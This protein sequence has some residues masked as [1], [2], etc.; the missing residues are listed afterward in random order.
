MTKVVW[1]GKSL[2]QG[3][4]KLTKLSQWE[5]V[6]KKA[7]L[8]IL[9]A[10]FR[11]PKV[12]KTPRRK[13]N[14]GSRGV[15]K[16]TMTGLVW[17]TGHPGVRQKSR[18]E[19]YYPHKVWKRVKQQAEAS[20]SLTSSVQAQGLQVPP[21]CLPWWKPRP[22]SIRVRPELTLH[23]VQN[24]RSLAPKPRAHTPFN[25]APL[26]LGRGPREGPAPIRKATHL[27][28]L[29]VAVFIAKK[30]ETTRMPIPKGVIKQSEPIHKNLV[31]QNTGEPGSTEGRGRVHDNPRG[32]NKLQKSRQGDSTVWTE[33]C[34]HTRYA[35]GCT[36]KDS[37]RIHAKA[38]ACI[39]THACGA[40]EKD[41]LFLFFTLYTPGL[42]TTF[43]I[44]CLCDLKL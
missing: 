13:T 4:T 16:K 7:N 34:I 9:S 3:I 28:L 43:L 39:Y 44:Y 27:S 31:V 20:C 19:N 8:V 37:R 33:M 1:P 23:P 5:L 42:L 40:G 14:A 38:Y 29:T 22:D 36:E 21:L 41:P 30:V 11:S 10:I 32:N 24:T 17:Q 35:W 2:G 15:G 26:H 25:L 18:F 12:N 6:S